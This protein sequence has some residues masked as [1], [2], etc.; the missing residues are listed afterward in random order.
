MTLQVVS[1]DKGEIKLTPS[2]VESAEAKKQKAA[3]EEKKIQAQ[4]LASYQGKLCPLSLMGI[5][6][7]TQ[8]GGTLIAGL[9]GI[10]AA[11]GAGREG[12]GCQGPNC[13]WFVP[14]ADE[15]GVVREGG[16]ATKHIPVAISIL[17]NMAGQIGQ[18]LLNQKWKK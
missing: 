16:C 10:P 2:E 1:G 3:E 6:T 13:M 15:H 14:V 4:F 9:N 5:G 7:P 17:T 18:G 8:Q 11:P 12:L